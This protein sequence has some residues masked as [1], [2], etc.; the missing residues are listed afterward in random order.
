MVVALADSISLNI[1]QLVEY[2]GPNHEVS[3]SSLVVGEYAVICRLSK[4]A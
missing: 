3:S 4:K 2:V 1:T